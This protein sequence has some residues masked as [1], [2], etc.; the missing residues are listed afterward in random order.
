MS[1]AKKKAPAAKES[2]AAKKPLPAASRKTPTAKKVPAAKKQASARKSAPRAP[3]GGGAAPS[4]EET[5][6]GL[7]I[8]AFTG[9]A[10]WEAWLSKNHASERGL[11]LK[12]FKKGAGAPPL[13]Y[14]QALDVALCW[15]WI[16]SHKR[17]Y[18]DAAWI[19][20]F[21]PRGP[22]SLWS[23]INREK[24]AALI[25]AKRMQPAGL[26]HVERAK[27]DGRWDNAYAS[28]SRSAIP[29]DFE[30]ALDA[31]PRAKAFF[32]TLDSANRYAVLFRIQNVKKA[33]TRAR[34]IVRFVEMLA[35]HEKIHA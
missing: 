10:D 27:A 3:P 2:S 14:A 28:Q 16:D 19:Q 17:A 1:P 15:G 4:L 9:P 20:R 11:W 26:V 22:R 24:V 13:T 32:S 6:D 35:R 29:E 12:L 31:N 34:N 30:A 8:I 7:P 18:D 5:P 23:Q 21:S 25:A 33:E